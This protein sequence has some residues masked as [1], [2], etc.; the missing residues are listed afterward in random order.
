M[1]RLKAEVAVAGKSPPGFRRS[2]VIAVTPKAETDDMEQST[3]EQIRILIVD[4]ERGVRMGLKMRLGCEADMTVVGEATNG[5]D[6][7]TEAKALNPDVVLIDYQMPV[8]DG[9]ET[10]REARRNGLPA[11]F[12]MLSGQDGKILGPIAR[13]AGAAAYVGKYEPD[14]VLMAAIR[15]AAA[16]RTVTAA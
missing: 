10:V 1:L 7:L 13:E 15:R 9:L 16:D 2:D 12:V 8:L 6:A 4:D 5:A 14:A 11:S 3:M